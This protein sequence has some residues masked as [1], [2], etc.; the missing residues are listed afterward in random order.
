MGDID[1]ALYLLVEF[2]GEDGYDCF[3]VKVVEG[4]VVW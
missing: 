3:E 1:R 4:L 2:E